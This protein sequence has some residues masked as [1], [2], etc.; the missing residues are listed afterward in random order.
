MPTSLRLGVEGATDLAIGA[1]DLSPGIEAGP[2]VAGRRTGVDRRTA[3]LLVVGYGLPAFVLH[4]S[5]LRG[6]F[7]QGTYSLWP[8]ASSCAFAMAVPWSHWA[9]LSPVRGAAPCRETTLPPGPWS[10][11]C[12]RRDRLRLSVLDAV[13]RQALRRCTGI[14]FDRRN[15]RV[16]T[17]TPTWPANTS[18]NACWINP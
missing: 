18:R 10:L 7:N 9:C 13:H 14:G 12:R 16:R 1:A 8:R 17:C 15:V 6:E 2:M 5:P 11:Q 3:A 4:A